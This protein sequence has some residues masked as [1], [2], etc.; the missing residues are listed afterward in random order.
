MCDD[1]WVCSGRPRSAGP[2]SVAGQAGIECARR[3]GP[4][5]CLRHYRWYGL[6][7]LP[8]RG[9][10]RAAIRRAPGRPRGEG[11]DF[12]STPVAA[13]GPDNRNPR[14]DG[15][16]MERRINNPALLAAGSLSRV[17]RARWQP[18]RGPGFLIRRLVALAG[19]YD[20]QRRIGPGEKAAAGRNWFARRGN[21]TY[22]QPFGDFPAGHPGWI[23]D[24]SK[25]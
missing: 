8:S 7:R 9:M 11:A 12:T 17:A 25:K 15:H 3:V 18:G 5:A 6:Q 10:T 20:Q 4:G 16:G 23:L 21:S 24:H 19:P 2:R 14:R 22:P 1:A 13:R